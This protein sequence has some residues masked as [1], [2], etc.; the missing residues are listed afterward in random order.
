MVPPRMKGWRRSEAG[1]GAVGQRAGDRLPDHGHQRPDRPRA[2]RARSPRAPRPTNWMHQVGDDQAAE[3]RPHVADGD[4]V[5]GQDDEIEVVQLAPRRRVAGRR[6]PT[7]Q[8]P[9]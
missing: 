6:P 5:Q 4:P 8:R 3:A 1:P 2:R 7:L 9:R